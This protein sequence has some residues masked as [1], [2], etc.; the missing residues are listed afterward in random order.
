M[1]TTNTGSLRETVVGVRDRV[2]PHGSFPAVV[3]A[4]EEDS[5]LEGSG[6]TMTLGEIFASQAAF[7]NLMAW[8]GPF[9]S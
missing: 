3:E 1:D 4:D 8:I 9:V 2:H 7:R 6:F 5:N